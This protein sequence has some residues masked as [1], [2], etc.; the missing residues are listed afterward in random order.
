VLR[1][2]VIT[3]MTTIH[4]KW[5]QLRRHKSQLVTTPLEAADTQGA[6]NLE[7]GKCAGYQK[8]YCAMANI[9]LRASG[10]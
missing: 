7:R 3:A 6:K 9:K 5:R 8:K 10:P 2:E 1:H 4:Q